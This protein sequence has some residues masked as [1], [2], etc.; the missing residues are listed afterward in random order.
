MLEHDLLLRDIAA[1]GVLKAFELVPRELF[2]PAELRDH[3]YEDT[4]LPNYCGQTISQPYIV[5]YMLQAL[6]L[7]ATQRVLEVGAG[8][9]YVVALLSLICKEV[10][11]TERFKELVTLANAHL[12]AFEE[13]LRERRLGYKIDYKVIHAPRG[14]GA[15][16]QAPF[17]RII[18]SAAPVSIPQELVNQ[19]A[20][21]GVMVLPAG[22]EGDQWLFRVRKAEDTISVERLLPVRFMPLF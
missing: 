2:V 22:P 8:S 14:L 13:V 19:L 12:E 5:A 4:P 15:P 11:A 17:D 16:K 6:E 10:V 18:V 20:V 1:E 9:G 7:D 3:A 21:D